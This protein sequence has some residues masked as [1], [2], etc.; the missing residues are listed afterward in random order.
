MNKYIPDCRLSELKYND[1]S[2]IKYGNFT[3]I[4]GCDN[5]KMIFLKNLKWLLKI[6]K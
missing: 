1:L 5:E 4:Y 2:K 3:E 6:I